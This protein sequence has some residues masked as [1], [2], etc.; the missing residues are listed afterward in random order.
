MRILPD[1][2]CFVTTP[3]VFSVSQIV[4]ANDCLLKGLLTFQNDDVVPLKSNPSAELGKVFHSLVEEA[5]RGFSEKKDVSIKMMEEMLDHILQKKEQ[6]LKSDPSTAQYANLSKTMTPLAWERK[7]RTLLD[8]AF[9]FVGNSRSVRREQNKKQ[10]HDFDYRNLSGDG[11][12]TEVPIHVPELRLKGRID[13]LERTGE[14]IKITDLKSGRVRGIDGEI[15]P[16]ISFQLCLYG[17]MVQSLSP[18]TKVTLIANDGEGH[19]VPFDSSIAV[20]TED[21]LQSLVD[22]LLP[23]ARYCTR[24]YASIGQSCQWCRFRHQCEEYLNI[25][26]NLWKC[27]VKWRLPL[28]S[29]GTVERIESTG[30]EL[31]NLILLDEANRRIKISRIQRIHLEEQIAI[32][33]LYLFNLT[34]SLP[35]RQKSMW[36]HP[37]NFYEIDDCRTCGRA[38][39]LEVFKGES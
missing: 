35:S 15:R 17:I 31:V 27:E 32:S 8:L 26:P 9:E 37:I 20:G 25:I 29:W 4:T 13:L 36:R 23:G 10:W 14:E 39:S 12:W 38:W 21:R 7:R 5:V 11:R 16:G 22:D 3:E 33:R 19:P 28:D 34:T 24:Q 1:P 30:R 18:K 6:L 2:I